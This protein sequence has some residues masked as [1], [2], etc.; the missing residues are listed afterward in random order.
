M[1]K[2]YS[3]APNGSTPDPGI[4][5]PV[6]PNLSLPIRPTAATD[7]FTMKSVQAGLF[8]KDCLC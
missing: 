6:T 5:P 4:P 2:E 3:S 8:L 7:T 1:P